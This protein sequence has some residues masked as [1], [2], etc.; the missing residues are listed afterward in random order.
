[1][2]RLLFGI[3]IAVVV[4]TVYMAVDC[5]FFDRNRI[6]GLPRYIWILVIVLV[7]VVGAV[8]WLIVGRGR[9]G[10]GDRTR[11][12][13]PDDDP[14]FLKRLDRDAAQEDR[15][16][17]LEQELADLD[18]RLDPGTESTDGDKPSRPDA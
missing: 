10:T 4:L 3:A 5:A 2:S 11:T 15:I 6:R 13:A 17:K 16:R 12:V 8:L 18:K 7:P 14:D 9:R 1:M